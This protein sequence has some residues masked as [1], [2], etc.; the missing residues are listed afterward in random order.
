V[1]PASDALVM[2]SL[3]DG[4][5]LVV[6]AGGANRELAIKTV[7][8]MRMHAIDILGVAFNQIDV[9]APGYYR[10]YYKHYGKYYG[11]KE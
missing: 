3:V 6:K 9:K 10:Y 2:G 11:T 8:K 1:V 5:L 4:V 7:E